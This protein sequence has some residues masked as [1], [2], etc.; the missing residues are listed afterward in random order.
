M[1]RAEPGLQFVAAMANDKVLALFQA[2]MN[3]LDFNEIAWSATEPRTVIAAADA[4]MC[5]SGTAALETMLVNRPMVVTYRISPATYYL[6]KYLRLDQA[7]AFSPAQ[8]PGRGKAG[9][10]TDPAESTGENLAR[11][12]Q[13]GWRRTCQDS[14]HGAVPRLHRTLR[15]DASNRQPMPSAAC[16]N[17]DRLTAG[18]DEAGRGPLAGP[19]VV[20]AVIL[21]PGRAIAGLDDSKKTQRETARGT[22]P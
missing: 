10:G 7:A 9:T 20:A 8:Y 2:A 19:G 15:C 6:A 14:L 11:E 3:S 5:A 4:V 16:W 17:H 21:D 1:I 18:V 13:H 22:V 12:T